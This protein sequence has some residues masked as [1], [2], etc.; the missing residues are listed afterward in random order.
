MSV[1]ERLDGVGSQSHLKAIAY[2]TAKE[3]GKSVKG[4]MI[5]RIRWA[6]IKS[7]LKKEEQHG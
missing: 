5:A 3:S 7:T 4:E 2:R 1:A 6:C